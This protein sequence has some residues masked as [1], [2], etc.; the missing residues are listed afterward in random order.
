MASDNEFSS[1]ARRS[2]E[3]FLSE[4]R[5]SSAIDEETPSQSTSSTSVS[6]SDGELNASGRANPWTLKQLLLERSLLPEP[7]E[8]NSSEV[9]YIDP[10]YAIPAAPSTQTESE[11]RD[12][13]ER[14]RFSYTNVSF[15][16]GFQVDDTKTLKF[17][18]ITVPFLSHSNLGRAGA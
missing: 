11:G 10:P 8:T 3:Y 6:E 4:T 5:H 2:S 9:E 1:E 12:G 18:N 15:A 16:V 14:R 13:Q 17:I 7:K